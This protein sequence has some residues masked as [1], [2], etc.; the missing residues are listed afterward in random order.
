MSPAGLPDVVVFVQESAARSASPLL[1]SLPL[2]GQ[3][4][5]LPMVSL[6]LEESV[7]GRLHTQSCRPC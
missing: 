6:P 5:G 7:A 3:L 2:T 4:D 1:A